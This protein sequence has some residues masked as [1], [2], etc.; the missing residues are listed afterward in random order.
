[1]GNHFICQPLQKCV[2]LD[3][4]NNIQIIILFNSEL[5][6]NQL[7][8]ATNR[9]RNLRTISG[10]LVLTAIQ[11]SFANKSF[12]SATIIT[13]QSFNLTSSNLIFKIRGAF[14]LA[15]GIFGA[16]LLIPETDLVDY[17]LKESFVLL[18]NYHKTIKAGY[19]HLGEYNSFKPFDITP[20][21][22][23]FANFR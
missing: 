19:I 20:D 1:M 7:S 6:T 13:R 14:P 3:K 22:S 4:N 5:T 16:V 21:L 12:T 11:G 9:T 23:N 15:E 17:V 18:I 8:C 2:Y 10:T